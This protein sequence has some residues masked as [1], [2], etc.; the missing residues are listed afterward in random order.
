M[1][2]AAGAALAMV[3]AREEVGEFAPIANALSVNLD[4]LD[5]SR[6]APSALAAN[7][8]HKPWIFDPVAVSPLSFRTQ[9]AFDLLDSKPSVIRGNASE[10]ISLS[11]GA[12]SGRGVDSTA[13]TDA[14]QVLAL[15][16]QAVVAV[17]G[18]TDYITDG[19][20]TVAL[21]NGSP[22]MTRVTASAARCPRRSRHS[23]A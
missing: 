9:F 22:L 8:A 16:T 14:V 11:G 12:A 4:T 13:H 2:L 20:R 1:L 23:S 15:K 18:S 7:S 10:I 19:K 17:T 6:H 3:I 21:S 5:R